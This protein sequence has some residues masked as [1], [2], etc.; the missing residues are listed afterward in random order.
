[1]ASKQAIRTL[2]PSEVTAPRN[3]FERWAESRASLI[4]AAEALAASQPTADREGIA[5]YLC[6]ELVHALWDERT[7]RDRHWLAVWKER[8]PSPSR[9]SSGR[10]AG[11]FTPPRC[12]RSGCSIWWRPKASTG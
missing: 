2:A 10:S 9:P 7:N 6:A 12:S 3:P 11:P 8:I 1:M 5:R 4:E